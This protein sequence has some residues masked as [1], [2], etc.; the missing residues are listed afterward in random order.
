MS[1]FGHECDV[2]RLLRV[3]MRPNQDNDYP[4][5]SNPNSGTPECICQGSTIRHAA[6]PQTE[7]FLVFANRQLARTSTR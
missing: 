6:L 5:F 3:L 4:F 1:R 2:Q 7:R